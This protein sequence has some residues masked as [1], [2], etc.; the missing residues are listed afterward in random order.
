MILMFQACRLSIAQSMASI[1]ALV[2]PEPSAPI[3]LQADDV[4]AGRDITDDAGDV[5]PVAVVVT[6]A[7]LLR[8]G[9]VQAERHAI[10][11]VWVPGVD[12][13][14]D[15][16]HADATARE[17]PESLVGALPD[18]IGA[19]RL[20]RDARHRADRHVPGYAGDVHVLAQVSKLPPGD[21]EHGRIPEPLLYSRAVA[22]GERLNLLVAARDDDVGAKPRPA[23]QAARGD[24]ATAARD[25]G[26][27]RRG[28]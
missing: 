4:R 15:D 2:C 28:P 21:F 8:A 24:P 19:D 12:S 14:V 27:P 11:Q 1:T 20:G 9:E 23:P 6:R 22:R 5:R 18:L 13:R 3:A 26:R 16:R 7:L 17:P 25:A 10:A